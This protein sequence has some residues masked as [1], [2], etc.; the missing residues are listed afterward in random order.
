MKNS[1]KIF[2][3]KSFPKAELLSGFLVSLIALPLSLGIAAAS[4]FPPIMGVLTAAIGGIIVSY[5]MGAEATI[6]GPAAGLIVILAGSVAAFR[7]IT[8]DPDA[9]W[10]L[11]AAIVA[12]AGIAQIIL[13]Y[14][15]IAKLVEI[16]PHSA[17][18]GMLAAIGIIIVVKQLPIALGDDP[19]INSGQGIIQMIMNIPTDLT[20]MTTQIAV[21]GSVSLAILFSWNYLR[22]PIFKKIPAAF[23]VLIAGIILGQLFELSRPGMEHFKPLV[24]INKLSLHF[25]ANFNI[26]RIEYLGIFIKYFIM[27]LLIGSLESLLS[28]KAI[29]LI[30]PSKKKSDLNKD[31]SAVGIGNSIS[32]ILGGLPMI[33]EIVRSSANLDYGGRSRWSNFFHGCFL[34][35]YMLVLYPFINMVPMASLAAMM[36]YAGY[37]LASPKEFAK[38]YKIGWEQLTIFVVTII[39]TLATDLL[40][41]IFS[42]ILT[43]IVLQILMGVPV[44]HYFRSNWVVNE[45][46]DNTVTIYMKS[47]GLFINYHTFEKTVRN[48]AKKIPVIV[49]ASEVRYLDHS[50]LEKF[51][52]LSEYIHRHGGFIK[53]TGTSHL[54][55]ISKHPMSARRIRSKVN[56]PV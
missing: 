49:D 5:F 55:N 15:R 16:F 42:G 35:L 24:K 14:A 31:L 34:L 39:T 1:L 27:M 40:I 4:G 20:H 18:H 28:A 10:K 48:Y 51:H 6:K 33:S 30:H 36:I 12:L 43:E 45:N 2:K 3:I 46:D 11:T 29:D 53:L 13:G 9:A 22:H 8:H 37:R 44:T 38:T 21:I 7:E 17:V 23:V 25:N 54:E 41:G 26:F 50:F 47:S 56:N 32:G 19:T 52:D